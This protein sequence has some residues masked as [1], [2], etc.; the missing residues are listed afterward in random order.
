MQKA[1]ESEKNSLTGIPVLRYHEGTE[2]MSFLKNRKE[3]G[4][5]FPLWGKNNMWF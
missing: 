3:G 2:R 1:H 4:K 5:S